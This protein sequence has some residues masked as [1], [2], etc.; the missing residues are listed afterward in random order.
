MRLQSEPHSGPHL[1]LE[2]RVNLSSESAYGNGMNVLTSK[3]TFSVG[4]V[5]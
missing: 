4:M 1:E 3:D 5:F 2:Q